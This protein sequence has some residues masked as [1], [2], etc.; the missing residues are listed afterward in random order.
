M[1]LYIK[2]MVSIRCK[3][4]VKDALTQLGIYY[5]A[6]DLGKV[7]I[8]GH[9]SAWQYD[10][11][12]LLLNQW[13]F[14]IM[15]LE[16]KQLVQQVKTILLELVYAEEPLTINLSLYLAQKLN[17]AYV[18]L[19]RL[20]LTSEGVS[21]EVFYTTQRIERVKKLL[22]GTNLTLTDISYMMHYS[23][24]AHLSGQFKKITG[25]TVSQFKKH[26]RV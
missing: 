14:E 13:G 7:E 12:S 18:K 22:L 21:I 26:N 19:A 10:Q 15:Q 6:I 17:V 3:L 11:L 20:F 16:K 8:I 5:K 2:N 1:T 23:S 25:Y 4:V 9:L 24:V